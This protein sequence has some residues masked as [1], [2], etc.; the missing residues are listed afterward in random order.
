MWLVTTSGIRERQGQP[1]PAPEHLRV[2][3]GMLVMARMTRASVMVV[4]RVVTGM[5]IGV[6]DGLIESGASGWWCPCPAVGFGDGPDRSLADQ[7][8]PW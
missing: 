6:C 4:G 3:T 8:L 2:V 5:T 7:P 1:E